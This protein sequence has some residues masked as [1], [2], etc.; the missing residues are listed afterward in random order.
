M[1]LSHPGDPVTSIP[2]QPDV[3]P[4]TGRSE[5]PARSAAIVLEQMW[6]AGWQKIETTMTSGKRIAAK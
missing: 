2:E 6:R 1:E 3:R 4:T 5:I